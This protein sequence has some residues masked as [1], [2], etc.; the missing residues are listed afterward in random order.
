MEKVIY[1]LWR[2]PQVSVE[3]WGDQLRGELARQLLE[4]GVRGLQLNIADAAVAPAAPLVQVATRPQMAAFAQVWVSSAVDT[5]RQP[6]DDII[7]AASART[8][9][10]LVCESQPIVNTRHPPVPPQRTAG[11]SQIA[12]LKRPPRLSHEAWLEAW[13]NQHTPVAVETQDN[14]EYTQNL[15]V[16][17]LSYDAPAYSGIVEECF[18]TA[19]MT[20]PRVFFDAVDDEEKFNRHL[21]RMMESCDRFI[22]RGRIDVVQ[23]SQYVI[24]APH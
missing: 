4:L 7:R 18:E 24:S 8:A 16:R 13:Q 19:A 2:D 23:T 9:A 3:R 15:V 21:G 6:V 10:Y 1:L 14:F 20:D 11:F 12:V 22:D 17:P 5:L